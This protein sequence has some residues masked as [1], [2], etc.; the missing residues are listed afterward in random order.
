MRTLANTTTSLPT[1]APR[2]RSHRRSRLR[3]PTAPTA[4]RWPIPE[5]TV[6]WCT[7]ARRCLRVKTPCGAPPVWT[8]PPRRQSRAGRGSPPVRVN[9]AFPALVT[10]WKFRQV[11][12]LMHSRSPKIEHL[13]RS[14]SPYLLSGLARCE[15]CRKALTA[16]EAKGGKYTYYV[17][18]S[19]LI[20]G[21][22]TCQTPG[23]TRNTLRD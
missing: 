15:S 7:I 23:S 1:M 9:R 3:C 20:Q 11:A 14:S 21:R 22:W 13:R 18:R 10:K 4:L 17:C 19:L 2:Q 16:S 12:A 5:R 6:V 8:G